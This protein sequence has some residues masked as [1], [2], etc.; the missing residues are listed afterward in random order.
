MAGT[1]Y[2]V[3]TGF[4]DLSGSYIPTIYSKKML[5]E[6]YARCILPQISNSDYEGEVRDQGDKVVIRWVPEITI[7]DHVKGQNLVYEEP[8]P[9]TTELLI[10]KG[11]YWSFAVDD[12][13]QKQA[14]VD[15]QN[16]WA[17][18]A[19]Q[20][21]KVAIERA[22]FADIYADVAAENKGKTAGAIEAAYNLGYAANPVEVKTTNVMTML[23]EAAAVLDE[24]NLPDEGRFFILPAWAIAKLGGSDLKDASMMGDAS[25]IL[26][27]AAG[28]LGMVSRFNIFA[29]NL[30]Y[31]VTDTA[32]GCTNALFGHKSAL[33]FA[34]QMVK[35]EVLKNPNAF[36]SLCRGLQVYGYKVVRPEALGLAYITPGTEGA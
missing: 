21:M 19:A 29:S 4:P 31:R 13:D 22:V 15:Y 33:T 5:F 23:L 12:V 30:L 10:D 7:R 2:P 36:G 26:R 3:A 32:M 14:D 20:R 35:T 9:T 11:K 16:K 28:L 18:D 1:V 25:S 34:S 6:F 24:Q 27:S 17:Q 8:E